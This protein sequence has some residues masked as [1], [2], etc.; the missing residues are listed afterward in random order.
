ME[1][2]EKPEILRWIIIIVGVIIS[3]NLFFGASNATNET[4]AVLVG[5]AF[6]LLG[7]HF[8]KK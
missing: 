1:S 2:K 4:T 3:F 8:K 5:I 7:L 6:L